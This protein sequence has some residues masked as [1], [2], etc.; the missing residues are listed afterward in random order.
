MNQQTA[1]EFGIGVNLKDHSIC[2]ITAATGHRHLQRCLQSVQ[3][4]VQ[5]G[6]THI[7]VIDGPE[8]ESK[9]RQTLSE[10][11]PGKVPVQIL[12][13]PES[14]GKNDWICHRIYGAM[15]FLVNSSWICYLDED[16]W[17]DPDHLSSLIAAIKA[18]PALWGFSLRKLVDADGNY[19][20]VDLCESLG[21]LHPIYRAPQVRLVDTNCYLLQ[22]DVAIAFS[23][24]WNRQRRSPNRMPPDFQLCTTLIAQGLQPACNMLHSVNYTLGNSPMSVKIEYFRQGN[25]I[26]RQRYPAGLPWQVPP[27]PL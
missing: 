14:T 5:P 25:A 21:S 9:V 24:I 1:T 4:Q 17:F 2:V 11:Q 23:P 12:T 27:A 3:A 20:D 26:M 18:K 19:L 7:L 15:P 8:F 22:R 6:L 16:N 13:L 10:M